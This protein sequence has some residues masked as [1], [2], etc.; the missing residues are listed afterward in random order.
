MIREEELTIKENKTTIS[1]KELAN[2]VYVLT[3]Q[4]FDSAQADKKQ[5]VSKGFVVAR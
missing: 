5:S 1:T 4:A 3:R 2:G